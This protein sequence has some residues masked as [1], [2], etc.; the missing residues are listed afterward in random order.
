MG[1]VL[2]TGGLGY[3]GGRLVKY[4]LEHTDSEIIV[5]SRKEVDVEQIFGS[6]RVNL[7]SS[8]TLNN[9]DAVLPNDIDAIIHLAATNEIQA[10][11]DPAGSIRV[12]VL[13]SYLLLQKAIKYKVKRFVY[14]S[15]AHVYCSPLRGVITEE[16]CPK[17]LHPYAITHKAFEDFL[18]AA[19]QNKQIEGVIVRLSNS[20]GAPLMPD[21]NRWTLL[22]NDLCRQ[23]IP[24]HQMLLKSSGMQLRDFV[25]LTD[26]C[27]AVYH[28][29]SLSTESLYDGVFNLGGN[30]VISV[31][32][33]SQ[34]IQ[35][36]F[37]NQF[38][39]SVSLV[40]PQPDPDEKVISFRFDSKRL[41]ESGFVWKN[42]VEEEIDGLINFCVKNFS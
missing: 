34:L 30:H 27:R 13:D 7:S 35:K 16:V 4:L 1:R 5:S 11:A 26:V 36:R 17:P 24:N 22:V 40:R 18:W 32:E 2:V 33:M 9:T 20:Y 10:A 37:I 25:T 12:N 14:F 6:K 3:I 19:H 41:E 23:V 21:V 42:N 39:R 38:N 28:L 8:C 15:T 31:F 29:L